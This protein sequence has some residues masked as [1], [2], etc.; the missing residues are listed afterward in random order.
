MWSS[1]TGRRKQ[2]KLTRSVAVCCSLVLILKKIAFLLCQCDRWTRISDHSRFKSKP[3]FSVTSRIEG[4]NRSL[5]QRC[6]TKYAKVPVILLFYITCS[7]TEFDEKSSGW[8][9][10]GFFS[11]KAELNL[12]ISSCFSSLISSLQRAIARLKQFL[13]FEAHFQKTEEVTNKKTSCTH[14]NWTWKGFIVLFPL[15]LYLILW[16]FRPLHTM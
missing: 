2:S 13:S 1:E 4:R 16:Y 9:T 15:D 12:R 10:F 5:R 11:I 8:K 6:T 7:F 14:V 3:K